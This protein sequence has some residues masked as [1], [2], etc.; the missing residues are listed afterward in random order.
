MKL[1]TFNKNA[2]IFQSILMK[3][4]DSNDCS[5]QKYV[6]DC[7]N[8]YNDMHRK[9]CSGGHS[10]NNTELCKIV[11]TFGTLYAGYIYEKREDISYELQPLSS[12]TTNH[13][14]NCPTDI[15]NEI[16]T[17][18]G[19]GSSSDVSKTLHTALGTMAGATSLLALLYKVNE[20]IFI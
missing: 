13:V 16:S 19:K 4:N 18:T 14:V 10:K 7:V 9:H 12:T 6:L 17:S 15:R 5:C 3:K 8:L 2:E 11:N 20:I 1:S